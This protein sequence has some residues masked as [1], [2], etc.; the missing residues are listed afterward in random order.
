MHRILPA[1]FLSMFVLASA[2]AQTLSLDKSGGA[3]PGVTSWKLTGPAGAPY[4]LLFA[5]NEQSTP[6]GPITLDIPLDFITV[7]QALP[8]FTG[9]LNAMGMATPSFS[10]PNEPLLADLVI[11]C[12]AVAIN[13]GNPIVSNLVRVTPEVAGTFAPA[14]N[15]PTVPI[16]GGTVATGPGGELLFVG[17]SGPVAQRYLSR[18]EEW[19]LA[20]ATFGVGLLSQSTTLADGRVL[21]TGGLG[22]DGQPTNAAALYD[23]ITQ[24]TTNLTMATARAGHGASLMGNGRVII[25]GGFSIF[26][27][28]DILAFLQSITGSTEIFDPVTGVFTAGPTLLEPRA[29]HTSTSVTGGQVFI[30]GGLTL[31]PIVNIPTVSATAYRFNPSNNSFGFPSFF[32]GARFLHSAVAL[33]NGKVLLVGGLTLDL[34]AF[35]TSLDPTQIVIGTRTDGQVFSPGILGFGTF[36]TANGMASGRAGAGVAALPNGNAVVTGGF[37]LT[38]D[39]PTSTFVAA[40]SE[41]TDRFVGSNNTFTPSGSM[42]AGRVFPV[43]TALPDGTILILGGGPLNAEIYQP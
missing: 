26:N 17:G 4:I 21:F 39:V 41:T 38:I 5:L 37:T 1:A 10:L 7:S 2:P 23:P 30:A 8:G 34:S 42:A 13:A 29:L 36:A 32:S 11:S 40:L 15:D 22:L 25:T 28:T 6:I 18:T 14:L 19:E 9:V 33:S 20:G 3:I 35:L 27:L 43:M 31:L 24:T 16:I 12:Q